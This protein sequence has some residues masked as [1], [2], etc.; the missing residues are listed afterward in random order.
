MKEHQ[1]RIEAHQNNNKVKSNTN[2]PKKHSHYDTNTNTS[3]ISLHSAAPS[4]ECYV[5][6]R[7]YVIV[8]N[9]IGQPKQN[10]NPKGNKKT[11]LKTLVVTKPQTKRSDFHCLTK[12]SLV[13]EKCFPV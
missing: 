6:I 9:K 2:K 10:R 8:L 5:F 13:F 7:N 12:E 4:L 3:S 1:Q 11:S